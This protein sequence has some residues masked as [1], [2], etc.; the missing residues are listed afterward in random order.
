VKKIFYVLTISAILLVP[1]AHGNVT[2]AGYSSAT[3]FD[4]GTTQ[5]PFDGPH[6]QWFLSCSITGVPSSQLYATVTW[7]D[8]STSQLTPNSVW[9]VDHAFGTQW[10]FHYGGSINCWNSLGSESGTVPFDVY[11][12][13]SKANSGGGGGGRI[14]T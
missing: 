7:G 4:Y 11:V 9:Y 3:T 10:P 12:I 13:N 6:I 2:I 1:V 8:G 14:P 5:Y